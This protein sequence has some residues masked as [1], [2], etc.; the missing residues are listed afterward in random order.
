MG[1]KK[2]Y[3]MDAE[4]QIFLYGNKESRKEDEAY[5][6]GCIANGI[7]E[8]VALVIWDKMAEFAS[9]AFNKSHAAAY[10]Y[11]SYQTAWLKR[12]YPLEFMASLL[13]SVIGNKDKL[14]MYCNA[15]QKKMGISVLAPDINQSNSGFTTVD[16]NIRFG[17]ESIKNVGENICKKIID[18]RN[19]N[20]NYRSLYDFCLRLS[21][22]GLNKKTI[23][24]LIKS[25]AFDFS[26]YNRRE[27]M[28]AYPRIVEA[29]AADS[30]A[31][32][33]GQISLFELV[34]EANGTVDDG[35]EIAKMEDYN[36]MEKLMNERDVCSLFISGHPLNNY[37]SVLQKTQFPTLFSINEDFSTQEKHFNNKTVCIAAFVSNIEKKTTKSGNRM[38][39]L[40]IQDLTSENELLCFNSVL[41]KYEYLIEQGK[42]LLFRCRVDENEEKVTLI[43]SDVFAMPK[44]S[45]APANIQKFIKSFA[46]KKP[47]ELAKPTKKVFD[48]H[49]KTNYK[50]GLYV[51]IASYDAFDEVAALLKSNP[52]SSHVYV[53][54]ASEKRILH[55]PNVLVNSVVLKPIL[56][57]KFG[58][59][60]VKV[61]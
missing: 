48:I 4:K 59:E 52:G 23:E 46:P 14:P 61:V 10:A 31:K 24:S 60:N 7:P 42:T 56:A 6:P 37:S 51:K 43:C 5:V 3:I 50:E 9:Y 17:L 36:E 45:D 55:S 35:P 27:L 44:N 8:N 25:G 11:V 47:R 1:K 26:G 58:A 13:T 21:S 32:A 16:N 38:A 54:L 57:S 29:A 20:G 40:T 22:Q 53:I 49:K 34:N 2:H 30:S 33:M 19:N 15:S 41:E 12:Y 28:F 39:I 18:E